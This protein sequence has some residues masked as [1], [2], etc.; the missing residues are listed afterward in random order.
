MAELDAP[1]LIA[2]CLKQQGIR[3]IFG[4][5]GIPVTRTACEAQNYGIQFVGMRNEQ[6]ASFAAGAIGYL[7]QYPAVC[8]TVAG[9]GMVN[10][11][12][13]LLNAKANCWPM[14]LLS[15]SSEAEQQGAL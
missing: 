3:F 5:V 7:T 8:L 15:A 6:A 9:P 11:I 1:T 2:K 14:I 12:P 4:I 10:A 13:G